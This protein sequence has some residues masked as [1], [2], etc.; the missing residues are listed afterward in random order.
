MIYLVLLR[1]FCKDLFISILKAFQRGMV[2][3]NTVY[4]NLHL[5][6]LYHGDGGELSEV[7]YVS[8]R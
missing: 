5:Q 4:I 6:T 8:K 1:H 2:N 3:Q 7:L